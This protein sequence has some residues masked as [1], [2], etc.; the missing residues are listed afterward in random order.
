MKKQLFIFTLI[1][2]SIIIAGGI[3]TK[4]KKYPANYNFVLSGSL[5]SNFR[6]S[7]DSV[8][9]YVVKNQRFL[10]SIAASEARVRTHIDS[11]YDIL[12]GKNLFDK[13][14][15]IVEGYY[16][17]NN[18]GVI[19]A[20]E[21]CAITAMIPCLPNTTYYFSGDLNN[22]TNITK[23]YYDSGQNFLSW[24]NTSFTYRY[25]TTPAN[26]YYFVMTLSVLDTTP[27]YDTTQ[28]EVGSAATAYE[29]YGRDY[30]LKSNVL[31]NYLYNSKVLAQIDNDSAVVSRKY[32][33]TN[34]EPRTAN[35]TV[36]KN[37]DTIIV[38]T[39]FNETKDLL[40]QLYM[41]NTQAWGANSNFNF[42]YTYIVPKTNSSSSHASLFSVQ[43]LIAL[44]GDD[45]TPRQ[46]NSTYMGAN[47]GLPY[48]IKIYSAGH[49]KTVL[50]VGSRWAASDSLKYYIVAVP[51]ANYI[52]VVSQNTGT[53]QGKWAFDNAIPG[54]KLYHYSKAT[55]TGNITI[56]TQTPSQ[57][58]YPVIKYT[59]KKA[60]LND[61]ELTDQNWTVYT[62][63]EL[64]IVED[65]Y[66]A[67]PVA[68]LDSLYAHAGSATQTLMNLGTPDMRM[69]NTYTFD[70]HGGCVMY[71]SIYNY[72]DINETSLCFIQAGPPSTYVYDSIY[73]SVPKSLPIVVGARTWDLRTRE[74]LNVA[75]TSNVLVV[76]T[77]TSE[78]SSHPPYRMLH[79]LGNRRDSIAS[80]FQMM[81]DNQI[82]SAED[83]IRIDKCLYL[84]YLA[85][86]KKMYPRIRDN[87]KKPTRPA[88]TFDEV[89]TYR[90]YYDP[91]AYSQN[92]SSIQYFKVGEGKYKLMIDYYKT[93]NNDRISL[94]A[95][96]YGYYIAVSD[97]HANFTM[98]S[99]YV[100][101]NGI[102]VS[103]SG[104]Y[105]WGVFD[106]Y[107]RK[108]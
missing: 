50:D 95:E 58:V 87:Y 75:P 37:G 11:Y 90:G 103:V 49:G 55:H 20:L 64:K 93:V 1:I 108:P 82:G 63:K 99:K 17:N 29:P 8:A 53:S 54:S 106:L 31:A 83:S 73:V 30:R 32:M 67:N 4:A 78:D 102:Y 60:Y 21:N 35:M 14:T 80:C 5:D 19:Y 38:R 76:T 71:Q 2:I 13:N 34:T 57:Q 65:Y 46:Y 23:R 81:Y 33:Q 77:A 10:D 85:P 44:T 12:P 92:A 25:F 18:N 86:T 88:N 68:S 51:D 56:G 6:A 89:V 62:G 59:T 61:V 96:L 66:I 43:E 107:E 84:W 91:H 100:S 36:I 24:N 27:N 94:P 41:P 105:G 48:G 72:F 42:H 69:L 101:P 47:H 26:C 22:M 98:R 79:Y 74:V 104:A 70:D 16:I 28:I 3:S 39:P 9:M 52:W 7:P 40:Q 45:A 15:M 97:K